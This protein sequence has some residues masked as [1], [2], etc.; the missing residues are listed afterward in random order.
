MYILFGAPYLMGARENMLNAPH[1]HKYGR[2]PW[3]RSP[4]MFIPPSAGAKHVVT[5]LRGSVIFV[6]RRG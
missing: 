1:R 5:L 4:E 2:P 3:L 6:K